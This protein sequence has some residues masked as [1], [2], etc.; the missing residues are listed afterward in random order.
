M[1][2]KLWDNILPDP[3]GLAGRLVEDL[4]G[5]RIL[6]VLAELRHSDRMSRFELSMMQNQ[7]LARLMQHVNMNCPWYRRHWAKAGMAATDVRTVKDLAWLPILSKED[8]RDGQRNGFTAKNIDRRRVHRAASGGTSGDPVQVLVSRESRSAAGAA[9]LRYLEW[10]G[11]R[12]GERMGVL[13]GRQ[14]AFA[15]TRLFRV[16]RALKHFLTRRLIL[17]TFFLNTEVLDAYYRRLFQ[18]DPVILRGYANSLY[19]MARYMQ[20]HGL[21]A[22]PSLRLVSSTSEKLT[23]DMRALIEAVFRA[24][25]ADQY[26]CTE[27]EGV[28]FECPEGRSLHITE[29][30]VIVEVVD[31]HDHPVEDAPGRILLTDLDNAAMP[32]I[33]YQVGDLGV[34][35]RG[36]CACGRSHSILRDVIGRLSDALDLAN[37]RQIAPA[38]WSVVFRP[39]PQI[40]QACVRVLSSSSLQIDMVLS[41]QLSGEVERYLRA[42]VAKAVGD[43]ITVEWRRV[44]RIP[45]VKSGKTPWVRRP[46]AEVN[47]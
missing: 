7:K 44:E 34:M 23:P 17:N 43:G 13:W 45:P 8:L 37:G 21:A 18:F 24:P 15:T 2:G 28:A 35:S 32:L 39:Y 1:V 11:R 10:W 36:P 5:T 25:V 47:F 20:E 33:R 40:R 3:L 38:Y 26:G 29:E 14:D 42:S 22:W 41:G 4:R 9:L 30:H 16:Q 27:V 6:P 46:E 31:D 12:F 19:L